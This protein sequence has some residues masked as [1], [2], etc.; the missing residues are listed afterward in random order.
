MATPH[1]LYYFLQ[2]WTRFHSFTRKG[3]IFCAFAAALIIVARHQEENCSKEVVA[4]AA[5][6]ERL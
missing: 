4:A 3:L 6:E 1:V 2:H 5:A